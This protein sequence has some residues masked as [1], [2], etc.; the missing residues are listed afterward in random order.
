MG[1][2]PAPQG[3]DNDTLAS[4]VA[5]MKALVTGAGSGVGKA[6]ATLLASHGHEVIATARD[7]DALDGLQVAARLHLDV[8][9]SASVQEVR[10]SVGP[11]DAIVNNAAISFD[12]PIEH[13]PIDQVRTMFETNV[14]GPV[15]MIQAF[16]PAMRERRSGVVGNVSSVAGHVALP[17]DGYYAATKH[18]LD[19]I[20][21]AMYVELGHFGV[22][23]VVVEPGF[24]SPGMKVREL[25]RPF[26]PYE[27][28]AN[29]IAQ[30]AAKTQG[31]PRPGPD[32]VAEAVLDA[33]CNP[34]GPMR[35]RVGPDAQ[36]I[37]S[38]RNSMNDE[39]FEKA[40]RQM[41]GLTW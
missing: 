16:V 13:V 40:V 35:R 24:I 30:V 14:L 34:E 3:P 18:A 6:T 22:R 20:S 37:L 7:L 32:S 38:A 41:A 29:Q 23:V 2:A 19:A 1:A 25:S 28:L 36:L 31:G 9:D 21:E 8:T 27:D 26:G 12:G 39:D 17:L 5:A 11:V 4:R 10:Q 33:L 15:R